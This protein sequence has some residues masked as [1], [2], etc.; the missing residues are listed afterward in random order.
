MLSTGREHPWKNQLCTMALL[1]VLSSGSVRWSGEAGIEIKQHPFNFRAGHHPPFHCLWA[2]PQA[3]ST[4][5]TL[6]ESVGL[7]VT[8]VNC[9]CR[10]HIHCFLNDA[11]SAG[12]R[13]MHLGSCSNQIHHV[14]DVYGKSPGV[15]V[16]SRS[17]LQDA[18]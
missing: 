4:S 16:W 7:L 12:K 17:K 15:L 5:A 3:D 6:D 8:L 1:V 18:I 9:H 10:E 2:F 14:A 13:S 11:M